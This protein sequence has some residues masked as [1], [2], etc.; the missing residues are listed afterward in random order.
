M[1]QSMRRLPNCLSM[2][3]TMLQRRDRY[4]VSDIVKIGV[5]GRSTTADRLYESYA[6]GVEDNGI[7]TGDNE[8]PPEI[9]FDLNIGDMDG[10]ENPVAEYVKA[11][12]EGVARFYEFLP[13][14]ISFNKD[15]LPRIVDSL[16][17]GDSKYC[18]KLPRMF[19]TGAE[20]NCVQWGRRCCKRHLVLEPLVVTGRRRIA[21]KG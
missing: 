2:A 14:G 6:D 4:C 11:G 8:L 1:M 19:T 15:F 13:I 9:Q 7:L 20:A 21:I 16:R 12:L 5:G 17:D 18:S 10:A 3:Y